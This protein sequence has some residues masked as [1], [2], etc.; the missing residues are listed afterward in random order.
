MTLIKTV[1]VCVLFF[2]V[3]L[4]SVTGSTDR[5]GLNMPPDSIIDNNLLHIEDGNYK[6]MNELRNR[7]RSNNKRMCKQLKNK[8]VVV[9]ES[10]GTLSIAEQALWMSNNCDLFYCKKNAKSG[11]GVFKCETLARQD[12]DRGESR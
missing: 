7:S 4:T 10:W 12:V 8:H 11:K 1:V 5:M 3:V 6:M 2:C 9:G